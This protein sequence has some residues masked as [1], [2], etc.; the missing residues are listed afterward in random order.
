MT[1]AD[2]ADPMNAPIEERCVDCDAP[3][4]RPGLP[5]VPDECGSDELARLGYRLLVP[6]EDP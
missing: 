1:V 2:G 5:M 6:P 3:L 4:G